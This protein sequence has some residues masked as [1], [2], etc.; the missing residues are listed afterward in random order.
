MNYTVRFKLPNKS[1]C[2]TVKCIYMVIATPDK[3]NTI[4]DD[5]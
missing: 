4:V 2:P 3:Y 1:P 5:W